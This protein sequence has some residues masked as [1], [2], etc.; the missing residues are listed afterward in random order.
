[1]HFQVGDIVG[2]VVW[3]PQG[4]QDLADLP[5]MVGLVG[6]EKIEGGSG[7]GAEKRA[8]RILILKQLRC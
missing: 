6:E 3:Q 4:V 2:H 7:D 8:R 5:P 1:L